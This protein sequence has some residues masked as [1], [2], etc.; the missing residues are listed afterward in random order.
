MHAIGIHNVLVPEGGEWVQLLPAGTFR[1]RDGR[2]PWRL[3][4]PQA[5]VRASMDGALDR[6]LL[7]DRDHQT[8]FAPRGTPVPAAGWIVDL[9]ARQDGIWGRVE[10]TETAAREISGREYRYLSPVYLYRRNGEI[11][12]ILRASLTNNPNLELR[13]VASKEMTVN[14]LAVELKALFALGEEATEEDVMAAVKKAVEETSAN[15]R[16]AAAA[17]EALGLPEDA[18]ETAVAAAVRAR[19]PRDPDPSRYVT[20][21]QYK[22]VATKLA[23]LQRQVAAEAA[24][25]LVAEAMKA[26]K[27]APAQ[28]DWAIA[29]ASRDADDFRR[30]VE[31]APVI[32]AAGQAGKPPAG[33]ADPGSLDE[34]ALAVCT[35]LGLDPEKFREQ[36]K[37]EAV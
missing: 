21:D 3:S 19:E 8:D 6:G 16:V 14:D 30:F 2:G 4:D 5:V 18:D 20:L 13:A 11:V 22:A 33:K 29:Y 31:S 32:V 37:K 24:E 7:I 35:A 23:E 25:R 1:G 28:K 17:R 15:A 36:L 27:I 26:G 9:E 12:R 10:W 34:D